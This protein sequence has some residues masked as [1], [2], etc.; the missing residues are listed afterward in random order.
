M[1]FKAS[2]VG[3]IPAVAG[4]Y[5]ENTGTEDL[6][7][8]ETFKSSYYSDIALNQWIRRL[9]TQIAS[10]HLNLSASELEQIPEKNGAVIAK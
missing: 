2:D 3:F 1:D 6:V 9:P 4:H 10:E 7:F 8:L 5:I